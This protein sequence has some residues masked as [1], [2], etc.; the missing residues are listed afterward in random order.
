MEEINKNLEEKI[1]SRTED[2][3]KAFQEL[4]TFFYRSSHDFRR[5]ITTFLGL[6]GV[7]KITVKDPNSLEL[8]EKVSETATSL[9]KMLAK[10]QSISDVGSQQMIFKEVLLKEMIDEI[11]IGFAKTI[12]QKR[13]TVTVSVQEQTPLVSYP[14]MIKIV[15]E[16]LIENAIHFCAMFNPTMAIRVSVDLENAII[17]V[18]DNGQGISDEY[19]HRIFDM[20]FRANEKSKGN[21]LGLYIAQKAIKRL[22]GTIYFKTQYGEGSVFTVVLPN[23]E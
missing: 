23:T 12:Q 11:L 3:R 7:A 14:A 20:Y 10:L 19:K 21:G 15:V 1:K 5:P 16:N 22:N 13:I 8:F 17:E 6:A 9:D 4:D 2:L 18:V